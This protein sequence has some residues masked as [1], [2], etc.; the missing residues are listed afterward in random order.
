MAHSAGSPAPALDADRILA[1]L[2]EVPYPG[3]TRDLVSFGLVDHASACGT[4]AKVRLALRTADPA[5]PG[6]LTDAVTARLQALGATQVTVEIV[7]PPAAHPG[8]GTKHGGVA[9]PWGDQVRL[10]R[11]RHVVA[12]GAG[13]GGVGKSTVAVNLA[14]ALARGGL[15]TGLLDADIYGPSLPVLLGLEDGARHARMTP[16]RHLVPL[17]AHGLPLISFGFFLGD[18]SPAVWRGPMV[19]KAVRQFA[20]GVA[21]PELD[22][23]V[24]DLPPGTG[25]VPL[26][27]AQS[28][29]VS[30]AVV[31]TQP[32]RLA[33]VEAAK[34]GRMFQKLGIPV[35]GVVENMTGAFG[36]GAG[37][38]VAEGLGVPCLG[39]VPFD[40]EVVIEGDAG[41]PTAVTRP[42]GVV[43]RAFAVIADRVAESLGWREEPVESR[44]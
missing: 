15:R 40:P 33:A 5:I 44:A 20:R 11:V 42:N 1:A 43:A 22:V 30:G 41:T 8:P 7:D 2:R 17:T 12:V 10:G 16:E 13:K 25:D 37:R 32:A 27:L 28:I 24:V 19:S 36:H 14:L 39:R 21:W 4:L 35:L 38:D 34:A 6:A 18:Q 26:S 31:V 9:D 3:M 29:E 23:L